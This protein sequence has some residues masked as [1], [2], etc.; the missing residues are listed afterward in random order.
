MMALM[1]PPIIKVHGGTTT[2]Q[3]DLQPGEPTAAEIQSRLR[4][5]TLSTFGLA[6]CFIVISVIAFFFYLSFLK[7]EKTAQLT[8]DDP[9]DESFKA[10][11]NYSGPLG[12]SR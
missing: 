2:D 1:I 4:T 10:T 8:R 5:M 7:K 3:E 9:E 12:S 6:A 11:N